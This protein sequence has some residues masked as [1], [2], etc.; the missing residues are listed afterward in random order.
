VWARDQLPRCNPNTSFHFFLPLCSFSDLLLHQSPSVSTHSMHLLFNVIVSTEYL[1]CA[2]RQA[3]QIFKELLFVDFIPYF[4]KRF[5][6]N[7][8]RSCG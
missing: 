5:S 7:L 4:E 8:V 1:A 6:A 3:S 2:E